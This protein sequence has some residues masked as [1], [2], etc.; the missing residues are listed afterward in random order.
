VKQ[1]FWLSQNGM[2]GRVENRLLQTLNDVV[3][4]FETLQIEYALIGGLASSLHGRVRVTEDVDIIV[5]CDVERALRTLPELERSA[6][7]PLFPEVDL[8]IRRSFILPLIHRKTHV[9]VDVSIGV[10]G[11]ENQIVK[12]SQPIDIGGSVF[13]VA[14]PEDLLL[15]TT[16][17]GRP[18]DLVDIDGIVG[19][20]KAKLDWQYCIETARQLEE[21]IGEDFV[22]HIVSIRQKHD[23]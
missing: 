23:C 8:I 9:P 11:F 21:A 2:L 6:F 15:M 14:T 5:L 7:E 13:F 20:M 18:Q 10:S 4:F 1:W 12:R 19:V 3:S 17:A 16:L 22:C